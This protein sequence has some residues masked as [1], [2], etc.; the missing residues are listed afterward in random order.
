MEISEWLLSTTV[1]IE[2]TIPGNARSSGTGF[3]FMFCI[4]EKKSCG[5]PAIVTNKHVIHNSIDGFLFFSA[6]N[7]KEPIVVKLDNFEKKWILH[8]DPS[9][10]LAILPIGEILNS[11]KNKNQELL[12][13]LLSSR[14]ILDKNEMLDSV[15]MIEDITVVGYPDGIWDQCNNKPIVRKGITATP[16]QLDFEGNPLFLVDAAI[17]PGSSGSPV[18]LFNQGAYTSKNALIPGPRLKLLGIISRVYN[19]GVDGKL[20]IIDVP[21]VKTAI[22]T[23]SVP[24]NLGIAIHARKLHEFE[25]IIKK[26][27]P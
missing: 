1:K 16:I 13:S 26:V 14:D 10:D 9:V 11:Y 24:N 3:F 7:K 12:C 21:T 18:Y 8:P 23:S 27:T 15:S 17:Y 5:I 25:H 22:I 2:T 19:H 6:K 4:D 20:Q